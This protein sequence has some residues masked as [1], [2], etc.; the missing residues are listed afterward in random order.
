MSNYLILLVQLC[1][2]VAPL[3]LFLCKSMSKANLSD[4][5][6]EIQNVFILFNSSSVRGVMIENISD[7][8]LICNLLQLDVTPF[9]T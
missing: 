1:D 7:F 4:Y 5:L 2:L 6:K 8:N 9:Q 3:V